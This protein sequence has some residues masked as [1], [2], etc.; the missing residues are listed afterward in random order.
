MAFFTMAAMTDRSGFSLARRLRAGEKVFCGWCTLASPAM[1]EAIAREGFTAVNLDQQHGQ[2]DMAA[3]IAAISALRLA[4]AAAI[5]RVPL[6]DFAAASRVLDLG[7]EGVI[8]PMINSVADARALV[9]ATKFP[10]LGERSWGPMRAMALAGIE[11]GKDYLARANAD[12]LNFAMIETR[13]ALDNVEAIA[14]VDGIDVLFVGPSDLSIT[15]SGGATLDPVSPTVEEALAH[16][17]AAARKA[18]KIAGIYCADA[19]RAL[20]CGERG[21][22]FMAVGSDL[23]FLRAGTAAQIRTLRG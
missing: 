11:D 13:A 10:P 7:A 18:G 1:A 21:F 14:A 12:T 17:L 2:F 15:L 22:R 23:G 19:A 20:A 9:A 8:M 4:G 3:T 16:V 6:A 5:V